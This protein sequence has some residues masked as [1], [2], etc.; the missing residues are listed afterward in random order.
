MT[1]FLRSVFA[2]SLKPGGECSYQAR[3][4]RW[5]HRS[6][7]RTEVPARGAPKG[8]SES[9]GSV[10]K[11][12][13]ASRR[14]LAQ[15]TQARDQSYLT[16]LIL[17]TFGHIPVG[18]ITPEL[19]DRWIGEMDR[20]P[21]TVVKA[22]QIV[23][24]ILSRSVAMRK[25]PAN[26]AKVGIT[27]PRVPMGDM[28]FL[29]MQEVESLAEAT[30]DHYRPMILMAAMTGLRWGEVVGLKAKHLDLTG[31]RLAVV[32]TIVEVKGDLVTKSP[33]SPASRRSVALSA[34]IVEMLADR[35]VI[36]D[37]LVFVTPDGLPIRRSNFRN[38][39]WVKAVADSV[40]DPMRFHDLRHT[41]AAFSIANGEH[42]KA[43]Q[44][45]LGHSSISVTLDRYGHLMPG[46]DEAAAVRLDEARTHSR[47]TVSDGQVVEMRRKNPL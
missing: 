39:I 30:G 1:L 43:I 45:R 35:P 41:H 25:L 46:M 16:S 40:G 32:E 13:M 23:G 26:P 33:K 21:A 37:A 14:G 17:P 29:T 8:A 27:L 28:R 11:Q 18:R 15:S 34:S 44:M 38:R 3:L 4:S 36:G 19:I 9:F 12:W 6:Q 5:S 10:S 24:S 20:A 31:H 2:S 22:Y 47:R 42:P 7:S